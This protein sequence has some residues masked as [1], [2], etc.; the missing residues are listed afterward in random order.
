MTQQLQKTINRLFADTV[1]RMDEGADVVQTISEIFASIDL[2]WSPAN[3]DPLPAWDYRHAVVE[4]AP[5]GN[6]SAVAQAVDADWQTVNWHRNPNYINDESLGRF[7]NWYGYNLYVGSFGMVKNLEI[8]VGMILISPDC[9]Y[10][11]HNH[12]AAEIYVP[13]SG[14]AEWWSAESDWQIQEPGTPI[15]HRPWLSHGT[16]TLDEPLLALFGWLGDTSQHATIN[17]DL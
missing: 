2:T 14:R 17:R 3:P 9:L 6:L 15:Y 4:N 8:A 1:E 7:R 16:R 11:P 10:P 5:A 13:I 12:L